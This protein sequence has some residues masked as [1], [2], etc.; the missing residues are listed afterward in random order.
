MHS[1]LKMFTITII[2][3]LTA[4]F[5]C[6]HQQDT[7]PAEAR[8]TWDVSKYLLAS[9]PTGALGV[10]DVR[11]TAADGDDVVVVGRIGGCQNPWVDGRAAF[12][13]VDCSVMV[14]FDETACPCTEEDCACTVEN[15]LDARALVKI[16][17]EEGKLITADAR[18]LFQLE[19]DDVVVLCGRTQ[20]DE[21]GNLTVH[22]SRIY[23]R[24]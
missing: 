11:E 13:L 8:R 10:M 20:R 6:Q 17:D 7:N 19:G 21:S 4:A 15:M 24:R 5:G 3:G 18:D 2:L 23:V 12:S 22:A 1:Y 14:T 16:V 9:E